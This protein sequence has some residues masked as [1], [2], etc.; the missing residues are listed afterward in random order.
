MAQDAHPWRDIYSVSEWAMILAKTVQYQRSKGEFVVDVVKKV[1]KG[2]ESFS[3]ADVLVRLTASIA[4]Y[5]DIQKDDW[6]RFDSR[7]TALKAINELALKYLGRVGS[8]NVATKGTGHK[9]DLSGAVAVQP[10][11]DL[12]VT[13]LAKRALK[14][15]AYLKKLEEFHDELSRNNKRFAK[16]GTRAALTGR[17]AAP[18]AQTTQF[19]WGAH[20]LFNPKGAQTEF[21]R[22]SPYGKMEKLDPYHRFIGF[23][24]DAAGAVRPWDA[25][26]HMAWALKDYLEKRTYS[27]DGKLI[28]YDPSYKTDPTFYEWLEYHPICTQTLGITPGYNGRYDTISSASYTAGSGSGAY[29]MSFTTGGLL[30]NVAT[31][32]TS[33]GT[34]HMDTS[35]WHSKGRN[36]YGAFIWSE[37]GSLHIYPHGG[38]FVHS[39]FTKGKTVRCAGLISVVAGK[40]MGVTDESGHYRPDALH[41]YRFILWPKD[42]TAL[43]YQ[44][45]A[46]CGVKRYTGHSTLGQFLVAY[47]N[48]HPG[49]A[50]PVGWGI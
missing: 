7:I 11:L 12:Y 15:A 20:G 18:T 25:P 3:P 6:R 46:F 10:R 29:H 9:P 36:E 28:S 37:L 49:L 14:K 16:Y 41:M 19:P 24:A 26:R 21:L 33:K 8:D 5:H 2:R 48:N 45:N 44:P 1:G 40:V 22:L 34:T 47:G 13:S 27:A 31:G 30:F 50:H 4:Q 43:H 38:N 23:E 42:K 17:L 32:I 39:C 35:T